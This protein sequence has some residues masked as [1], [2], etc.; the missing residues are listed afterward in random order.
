MLEYN[1]NN[2]EIKWAFGATSVKIFEK[3]LISQSH[4]EQLLGAESRSEFIRLL[5][6][7]PYNIYVVNNNVDID[8]L[9]FKGIMDLYNRASKL[10][11]N[12]RK[13]LDVLFFNIDIG[14]LKQAYRRMVIDKEPISDNMFFPVF[15][16]DN[17]KEC[18]SNKNF[19]GLGNIGDI[20][21]SGIKRELTNI[22]NL[23]D[24][25]YFKRITGLQGAKF[26]KNIIKIDIDFYNFRLILRCKLYEREGLNIKRDIRFRE[27]GTINISTLKSFVDT[28]IEAIIDKIPVKYRDTL[29]NAWA[30]YSEQ[31]NFTALD[32]AH[33]NMIINCIKEAHFYLLRFETVVAYIIAV[34]RELF[35][36]RRAYILANNEIPKDDS[37]KEL[38]Y[39]A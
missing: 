32:I 21:E 27:G 30:H 28:N 13:W 12:D 15:G 34:Q 33:H 18:F 9:Y 3:Q 38:T 5:M 24:D 23:L 14:F 19:S 25:Y 7:T 35:L 16:R 39:A 11:D 10:A 29:N 36:I 1:I 8:G 4:I 17:V 31:G 37:E 26:L 2:N 6:D 22:D 20:I